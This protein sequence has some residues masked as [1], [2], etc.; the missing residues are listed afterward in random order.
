MTN[1]SQTSQTITT[2][3]M[4]NNRDTFKSIIHYKSIIVCHVEIVVMTYDVCNTGSS[5]N[6]V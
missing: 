6:F 1:K 4:K 5:T 3:V 2:T